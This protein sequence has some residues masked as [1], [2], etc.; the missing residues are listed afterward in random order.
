MRIPEWSEYLRTTVFILHCEEASQN[1]VLFFFPFTT[2]PP[3]SFKKIT[4]IPLVMIYSRCPFHDKSLERQTRRYFIGVAVKTK[5][6]VTHTEL[7]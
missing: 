4:R 2:T 1:F 5:Y 6:D 7:Q 3:P